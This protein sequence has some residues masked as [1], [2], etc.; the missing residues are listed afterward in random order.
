MTASVMAGGQAGASEA[1]PSTVDGR[2]VQKTIP[3]GNGS[4]KRGKAA[5][6]TGR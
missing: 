3:N 6:V 4:G 1:T 2:V 5:G